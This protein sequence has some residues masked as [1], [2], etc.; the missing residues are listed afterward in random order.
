MDD[1]DGEDPGLAGLSPEFQAMVGGLA[2]HTASFAK[3]LERR[4]AAAK[5]L[6]KAAALKKDDE[7]YLESYADL[8]IHEEMLRD[9]PRVDAYGRA[10]EK[11]GES[12]KEGPEPIRVVDVGSGTGVLAVMCAKAGAAHVDAIEA[13]RIA[14]FLKQIVETNAVASS[15]VEVH[16][17]RAEDVELSEPVDV[18]VSEWMGYFLLFENMLPSVL[19]VRDRFLKPGGL[20][21]PSACRLLAAPLEDDAWRSS[22]IDFWNSVHGIDMSVLRPLAA[23]TACEKPQHRLVPEAGLLAPPIQ[24]LSIDLATVQDTDLQKFEQALDFKV[25]AGRRLDGIATWFECDFGDAGCLLST[26]PSE[27]ATHWRQTAFYFR[28]PMEGGGGIRVTGNMEVERLEDFSRGY[29][30]T[31]TLGAPGRKSRTEVFELR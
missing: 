14:Y 25:P 4:S 22:K 5:A 19:S 21:L 27:P 13:S 12:W 24:L 6:P 1:D 2:G 15:V 29:R 30:V 8:A 17:C 9:M 20:M 3:I 10:I 7:V 11:C 26:S 16:E 18:V 31:F 28:Q 23:A